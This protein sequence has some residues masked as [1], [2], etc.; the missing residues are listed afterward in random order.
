M[1]D[2][3]SSNRFSLRDNFFWLKVFIA[4]VLL[5]IMIIL[6]EDAFFDLLFHIFTALS[7]CCIPN[8]FLQFNN[9]NNNNKDEDVLEIQKWSL[10]LVLVPPYDDRSHV[11]D[12]FA[13]V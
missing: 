12:E 3:S 8:R 4:S 6:Q 11:D 1:N 5:F 2:S 7:F 10:R 9:N 13:D